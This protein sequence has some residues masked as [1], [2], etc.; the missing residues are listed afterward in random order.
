MPGELLLPGSL[1]RFHNRAFLRDK[2]Q[3]CEELQGLV[4]GTGPAMESALCPGTNDRLSWLGLWLFL[5]WCSTL[6]FGEL[7]LA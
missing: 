5:P 4:W 2:A 3:T 7:C 6:C 1:F